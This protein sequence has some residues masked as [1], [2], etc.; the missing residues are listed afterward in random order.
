MHGMPTVTDQHRK[1]HVLAGNWTAEETIHPS[2]WDP[3]GGPALGRVAAKVDLD[4]FF[5][6]SDYVQERGGKVSYRGH[7]V[8]GYDPQ[9]GAYTLNWFDSMGSIQW[10]TCRGTWEG[11]KLTFSQ[12]NPM[13]HARYVYTFQGEGRYGF[14]I[15]HSQD[16]KAWST[17]MEGAYVRK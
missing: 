4:G 9:Q 7:G 2:P 17:F 10:E 15:E 8:F 16:G 13:G 1:L 6:V 14:A 12:K 5:V 11:S 3:K